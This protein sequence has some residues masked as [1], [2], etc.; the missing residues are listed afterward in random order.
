MKWQAKVEQILHRQTQIDGTKTGACTLLW[1][2]Q[3]M[4]FPFKKKTQKPTPLPPS[5][6][7]VQIRRTKRQISPACWHCLTETARMESVMESDC[8]PASWGAGLLCPCCCA[9]L[10]LETQSIAPS[11]SNASSVQAL[12]AL[13]AA[14]WLSA[15]ALSPQNNNGEKCIALNNKLLLLQPVSWLS[16][17]INMI[18]SAVWIR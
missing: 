4:L 8:S 9:I 15:S 3:D 2:S 14:F 10:P 11:S 17:T 18:T 13:L 5:Q 12:L 1:D 16:T 6:P 7:S